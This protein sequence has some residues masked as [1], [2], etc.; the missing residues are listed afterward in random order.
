M[1][2]MGIDDHDP[3]HFATF[4]IMLPFNP[5]GARTPNGVHDRKK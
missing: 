5:P 4:E 3:E 1:G 2:L